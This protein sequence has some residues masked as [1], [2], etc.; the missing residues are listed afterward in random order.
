M[1][2]AEPENAA[3]V[4]APLRSKPMRVA[5]RMLGSGSDVEGRLHPLDEGRPQRD[6]EKL[7]HPH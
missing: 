3:A 4:F 1:Q 6:P 5:Y 7:R 2:D